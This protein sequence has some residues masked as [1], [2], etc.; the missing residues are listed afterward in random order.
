MGTDDAAMII[1]D[2]MWFVEVLRTVTSS[3][4]TE[5]TSLPCLPN[6]IP[7]L[8]EKVILKHMLHETQVRRYT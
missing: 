6:T 2:I 5:K 3:A 1:T 7:L 8:T 4:Q